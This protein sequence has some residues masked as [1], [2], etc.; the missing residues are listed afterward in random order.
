MPDLEAQRAYSREWQ[1]KRRAAKYAEQIRATPEHGAP[2]RCPHHHGGGVC[3]GASRCARTAPAARWS[4][5]R[6]ASAGRP[7]SAGTARRR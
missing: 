3:G 1:R 7:G 2:T 5:A 4:S 6:C